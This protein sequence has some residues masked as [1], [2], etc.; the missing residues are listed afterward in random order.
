MEKK[1]KEEKFKWNKTFLFFFK[2]L[3]QDG[4]VGTKEIGEQDC[5]DNDGVADD[6]A[7]AQ[8]L[9]VLRAEGQRVAI[10]THAG[11]NQADENTSLKKMKGLPKMTSQSYSLLKLVIKS[12][13]DQFCKSFYAKHSV[14]Y[15]SRQS[16]LLTESIKI[17][18]PTEH[19]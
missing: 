5:R 9:V 19:N 4:Q 8:E 12:T 17:Y 6:D 16:V 15:K 14:W 18:C 7:F 2:R 13:G 11:Q 10:A 3:Y 1:Y